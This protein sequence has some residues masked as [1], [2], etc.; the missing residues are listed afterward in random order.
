MFR[1]V[2]IRQFHKF[3]ILTIMLLDPHDAAIGWEEV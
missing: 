2:E 3:I 1:I